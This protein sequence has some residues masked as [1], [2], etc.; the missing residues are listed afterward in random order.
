[1][2]VIVNYL[3]FL[4]IN[5]TFIH[6]FLLFNQNPTEAMDEASQLAE[7]YKLLT[8]QLEKQIKVRKK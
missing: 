2:I 7:Q 3:L 5:S 1:M 6:I 8:M 4:Q